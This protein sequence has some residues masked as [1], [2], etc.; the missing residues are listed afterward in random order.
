MFANKAIHKC[1]H[2]VLGRFHD[3]D[4]V[5]L[6]YFTLY[7]ICILHFLGRAQGSLHGRYIIP[8]LYPLKKN[9]VRQVM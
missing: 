4:I 2:R 9:P 1:S 5:F 7:C 6:N 8:P 3:L